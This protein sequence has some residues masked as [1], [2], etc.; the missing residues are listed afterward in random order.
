LISNSSG[1]TKIRNKEQNK[2]KQTNTLPQKQQQQKN[3]QNKTKTENQSTNQ[4][5][6]S[7]RLFLII[8]ELLG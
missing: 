8:K 3:Q 2:T 4:T 6:G 1:I 5:K 7:P